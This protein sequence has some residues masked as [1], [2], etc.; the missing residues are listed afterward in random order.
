MAASTSSNVPELSKAE[1]LKRYL[2]AD[3]DAKKAKGNLKK[4]RRKIHEK[5]W[6]NGNVLIKLFGQVVCVLA[7][8]L[9]AVAAAAS[10]CFYMKR[11][12][13]SLT[14]TSLVQDLK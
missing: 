11:A 1:Y 5:G 6:V 7:V 2:S 12:C 10:R 3:K 4:K 13:T 14:F 8:E 9:T